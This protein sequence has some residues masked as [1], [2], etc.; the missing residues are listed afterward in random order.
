MGV[1]SADCVAFTCAGWR[2]GGAVWIAFAFYTE[3]VGGIPANTGWWIGFARPQATV[4]VGGV[5][6]LTN[7]P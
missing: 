7:A 6:L 1:F 2:W 5:L 3:G 4:T